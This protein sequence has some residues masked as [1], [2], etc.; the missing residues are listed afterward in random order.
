MQ[1]APLFVFEDARAAREFGRWVDD[2]FD[3]IKAKAEESGHFAKL[4]RIEQYAVGKMRWLRF[5]FRPVTPVA[6]T[7]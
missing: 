7:W 1:R 2:H 5:D 6:R 3:A 4:G